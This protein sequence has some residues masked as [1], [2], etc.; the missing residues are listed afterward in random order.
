[1]KKIIIA[2]CFAFILN[3]SEGQI[4]L[5]PNFIPIIFNPSITWNNTIQLPL[6][7]PPWATAIGNV[8]TL[9]WLQTH[10]QDQSAHFS[11][12]P[13]SVL[14]DS[15]YGLRWKIAEYDPP[16]DIKAAAPN[17]PFIPNEYHKDTLYVNNLTFYL[18]PISDG[19]VVDQIQ[20]QLRR[21]NLS[22]NTNIAINTHVKYFK[23]N[24]QNTVRYLRSITSSK[25]GTHIWSWG[26]FQE[27]FW[28]GNIVQ[29]VTV[30][31][32]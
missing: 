18:A 23:V 2:I 15:L 3:K 8:D 16:L 4:F 20:T 13:L 5:P 19:G 27:Y 29:S 14:W 10:I 30:G 28:G 32:Y 1:M 6:V 11:G 26:G 22:N 12:K 25:N 17:I 9:Q 21:N 24:F 7:M 31:E